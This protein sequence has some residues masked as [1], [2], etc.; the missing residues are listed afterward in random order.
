M[1][2]I[3][4]ADIIRPC[5]SAFLLQVV[6]TRWGPFCP[7]LFGVCV[8]VRVWR[9]GS[10]GRSCIVPYGVAVAAARMGSLCC[11]YVGWARRLLIRLWEGACL[12]IIALWE[13]KK[14]K[15]RKKREREKLKE[16]EREARKNEEEEEEEERETEREREAPLAVIMKWS[17]TD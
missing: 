8:C 14:N 12:W 15:T 16:R 17:V 6:G 13:R 2:D 9:G 1:A 11:D 10:R 3:S 4:L 5:W 7:K